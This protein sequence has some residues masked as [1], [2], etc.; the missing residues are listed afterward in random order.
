MQSFTQFFAYD[1]VGEPTGVTYPIASGYTSPSPIASITNVFTNGYLGV[2]SSGSTDYGTLTYNPNGTVKI[3]KH[4]TNGGVDVQDVYTASSDSRPRPS[5]I[6]FKG[7]DDCPG[8]SVTS[9]APTQQ[10]IRPAF[11]Q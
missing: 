4:G 5:S 3:V 2:V 7:W 9:S 8:L 10:T 6:E 1:T 11:R